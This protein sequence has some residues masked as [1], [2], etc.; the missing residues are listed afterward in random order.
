VEYRERLF[1]PLLDSSSQNF[2]NY[3]LWGEL[4]PDSISLSYELNEK[5]WRST[6]RQGGV[7]IQPPWES[8]LI[9]DEI[10]GTVFVDASTVPVPSAIWLLG[11]GCVILASLRKFWVGPI[12]K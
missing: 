6:R 7:I 2:F 11:S 10:I 5:T 4:F 8:T 12:N 1:E 9:A 3:A